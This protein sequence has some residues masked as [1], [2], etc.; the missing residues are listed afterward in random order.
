MMFFKSCPR[1]KGDRVLEKDWDGHYILCLACGHMAYPNDAVVASFQV[2][3][4]SA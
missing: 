4:K 2:L 1:C 3:Q